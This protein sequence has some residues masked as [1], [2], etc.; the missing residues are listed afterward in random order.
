MP[1]SAHYDAKVDKELKEGN[2]A[3][4]AFL[5]RSY[6]E[7]LKHADAAILTNFTVGDPQR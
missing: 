1:Y 7:S 4:L 5:S 6:H 2:Y 3:L